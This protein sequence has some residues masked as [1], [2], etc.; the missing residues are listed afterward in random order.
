M[1]HERP[2]NE[3]NLI[4]KRWD[5]ATRKVVRDDQDEKMGRDVLVRDG[6]P[7]AGLAGHLLLTQ[8]N[9]TVFCVLERKFQEPLQLLYGTRS[10]SP[11]R[12]RINPCIRT[13]TIGSRDYQLVT[14]GGMV[15]TGADRH[16][17]LQRVGGHWSPLIQIATSV[18]SR[19][20]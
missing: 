6:G 18:G 3:L 19:W 9:E 15:T 20:E 2:T 1:T 7:G 16:H 14:N 4:Y 10:S 17:I 11:T 8:K 13:S 12:C 5:E